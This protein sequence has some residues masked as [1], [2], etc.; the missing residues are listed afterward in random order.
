MLLLLK[1][2]TKIQFIR[3]QRK[4]S[5]LLIYVTLFVGEALLEVRHTRIVIKD[6]V[7]F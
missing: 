2:E 1:F 7:T 6:K 3:K 5:M 4:N